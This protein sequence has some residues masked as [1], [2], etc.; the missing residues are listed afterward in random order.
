[1]S[2]TISALR[3]S[4]RQQRRKLSQKTREHFNFNIHQTFLKSGLLLR[5]SSIAAYLANDGEPS[6]EPLIQTCSATKQQIFLPVIQK[7]ALGFS[8]YTW[9]ENL[10]NNVFNIPEPAAPRYFPAKFL[11][12]IL[13]PL[14]G[15]D[16]HGNRLG[17]GGGYYDRSLSFMLQATCKKKPLLIGIAYSLQMVERINR[18][19]WDVP[20]DAII[21][22]KGLICFSPKARSLLRK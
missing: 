9:G 18:Q 11:S 16:P 12:V 20:L 1:M 22:E 14:V 2:H 21:T 3:N 10:N 7:K 5:A 15:F 17:M 6:I 19:P 8:S 4:L 13:M